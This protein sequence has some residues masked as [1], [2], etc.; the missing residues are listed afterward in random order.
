MKRK[1][2][3]FSYVG[4]RVGSV[5]VMKLL[6]ERDH[7][8]SRLWECLCDCGKTKAI[9][10]GRLTTSLNV[11]ADISCGCKKIENMK[12]IASE[13]AK[14]KKIT[15]PYRTPGHPGYLTYTTWARMIRKC[16]NAGDTSYEMHGGIGREVCKEW[17]SNFENFLKDM[18]MRDENQ[19]LILIDKDKHFEPGNCRWGSIREERELLAQWRR[20]RENNSGDRVKLGYIPR[21]Y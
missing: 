16:Y 7:C 5:T 12:R 9:S 2:V 8:G 13:N 15:N 1:S 10:T 20:D 21:L 14:M 19:H 6:D 11:K 3:K 18:G 17:R 4:T